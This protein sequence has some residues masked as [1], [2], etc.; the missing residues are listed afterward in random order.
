MGVDEGVVVD[1]WFCFNGIESLCVVD[2]FIMLNVILFNINVVVIMIGEK[3]FDM[4]CED[5]GVF[6]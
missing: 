6:L 2:V 1:L 4:I 5:Y 3:V